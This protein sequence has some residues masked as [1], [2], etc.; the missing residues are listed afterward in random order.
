MGAVGGIAGGLVG[1]SLASSGA[2]GSKNTFSAVEA[3]IDKQDFSA[4]IQ[5][6]TN[7]F[8]NNYINQGQLAN[9]LL[10]QSRGQGP[11]IAD[12]QL[13]NSLNQATQQ[14]T[15]MI[16]SQK[17][18]NPAL[19]TRMA[20]QQ[21]AG[22]QQGAAGQAQLTRAQQQLAAQSALG[23]QYGQM[24][25]E[26]LSN[27]GMLQNSQAQQNTAMI[28]SRNAANQIGEQGAQQ[29][30]AF[31]QKIVGGVAQGVGSGMSSMAGGSSSGASGSSM[32]ML[33][34]YDGG[35]IPHMSDGGM[36]DSIIKLAPL[37]L[38]L[39][40]KGG[41][42]PGK[43]KISGDSPQNDT[44]P[45]MLSPGEIVIPRTSAQNPED[46][47]NFVE[48]IKDKKGKK[49]F[50]DVINAHKKLESRVQELEQFKKM[51][52]GGV[53]E[54]DEDD[55]VFG[56]TQSG[57]QSNETPAA[58]K[59]YGVPDLTPQQPEPQAPNIPTPSPGDAG[60]QP[61][62]KNSNGLGD[63]AVNQAN[64]LNEMQ[65]ANQSG[66]AASL[67]T[68]KQNEQTWKETND[69]T[70][71][72]NENVAKNMDDMVKS[73]QQLFQ[74]YKDKKIDPN[75]VWHNTS[76][77]GKLSA[78]IGVAF[79]AIG[80]AI[81]GQ[82][83]EALGIINRVVDQDIDSQKIDLNQKGSLLSKNLD[84]Y[85]NMQDALAKTRIDLLTAAQGKMYQTAA[86]SG[87]MQA[88]QQFH[89]MNAQIDAQKVQMGQ[90]LA[91][92]QALSRLAG[93]GAGGTVSDQQRTSD[94]E[95]AGPEVRDRWV[96]ISSL[97][98]GGILAPTKEDA[99]NIKKSSEELQTIGNTIDH[100][101]NFA[102]S[103]R[104]APLGSI[105]AFG[106]G[107]PAYHYGQAL[108]SDIVTS[109]N[110][111]K[112]L[113]RLTDTEVHNF[114]KMV[115]DPGQMGTKDA[116]ARLQYVKDKITE[117]T[118]AMYGSHLTNHNPG[119]IKEGAPKVK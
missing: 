105:G 67:N 70:A 74:D 65:R 115:P 68:A 27:L 3:P 109:L 30:T 72:L 2:Y 87:S 96:N 26:Q 114:E 76:T 95:Y 79:G 23:S 91:Q 49:G 15:G 113:Q 99:T 97:P 118:N 51:Y 75:Q 1:G 57:A 36:M 8:N 59:A 19:A 38:M 24:S 61:V 53:A 117:K 32:S 16:A 11:N 45:T 5:Q 37:A 17:G 44:V 9:A 73:N 86:Q 46:A 50:G 12:L 112:G 47:K 90:S 69:A 77:A 56:G 29:N 22:M 14:G 94:L 25:Q 80:S 102:D 108:R 78:A 10:A 55:K 41:H 66:L 106:V 98:N 62:S 92:R 7:N 111:L 4:D 13:Q 52:D 71:A 34:A 84:Y 119:E 28:N 103:M 110:Q 93:G 39:A 60:A 21:Q 42:V 48:S 101:M 40:Q 85:K 18:I 82:P 58:N 81:T 107:T 64:E 33:G 31:G 104:S 63:I 20:A 100:A 89:Q 88:M 6:G 35:K 83:N 43:A 116:M 54:Q